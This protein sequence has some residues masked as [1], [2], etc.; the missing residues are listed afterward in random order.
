MWDLTTALEQRQQGK[1]PV[2][3]GGPTAR[4]LLRLLEPQGTNG[5][6]M[7]DSLSPGTLLW[8]DEAG[9]CPTDGADREGYDTDV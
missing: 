3:D 1:P 9:K 8:K 5:H 4:E 2:E 6:S 7:C